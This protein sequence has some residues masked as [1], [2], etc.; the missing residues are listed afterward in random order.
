MANWRY[1][2]RMSYVLPTSRMPGP[3]I[4]TQVFTIAQISSTESTT[5][6]SLKPTELLTW[7]ELKLSTGLSLFFCWSQKRGDTTLSAVRSSKDQGPVKKPSLTSSTVA[8][9]S[10]LS[11]SRFPELWLPWTWDRS[12]E[13]SPVEKVH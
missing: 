1:A 8:C 11:A 2:L 5:N 9:Q 4:C 6:F 7:E 13:P 12:S 10:L 3:L